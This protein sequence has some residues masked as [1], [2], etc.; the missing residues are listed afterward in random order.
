MSLLYCLD[1]PNKDACNLFWGWASMSIRMN[2]NFI[3]V[4]K[5]YT[6]I[7]CHWELEDF[8]PSQLKSKSLF[9]LF[10]SSVFYH[11]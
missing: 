10:F 9:L 6:P 4:F 11:L 8:A 7:Y 1:F 5:M 2:G 3:K